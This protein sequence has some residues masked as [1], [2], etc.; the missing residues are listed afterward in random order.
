MNITTQ[1]FSIGKLIAVGVILLAVL[2]LVV[3]PPVLEKN[4]VLG[5]AIALGA[6]V[7]L[8]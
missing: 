7:V 1:P 6:A 2:L 5:I 4:V 8:V 3:G